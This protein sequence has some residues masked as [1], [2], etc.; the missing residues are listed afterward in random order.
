MDNS[1]WQRLIAKIGIAILIIALIDLVY[2]NW[3]ILQSQ[4]SKVK[5]QNL[6]ETRAVQQEIIEEMP[7]PSVI[8]SPKSESKTDT[9]SPETKT[10]ETKTI[11][12]RETQTIVQT[13][14]K[15]IFIPIGS[16]STK[17]NNYEDL[18][19]LEVTIDTNKYPNIESA[20]FEASIWVQDGNGKMF[21]QL[22][23]S[24][25][26]HPVWSSEISTS[27]SK[28]TLTSSPTIIL[29]KGSRTYRVQAKT[30]LTSYAAH[31]DNA[32]IKITLK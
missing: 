17:N 23:N 25:D 7:S 20:V 5:S 22:F 2:I 32:R 10:V 14:Q 1:L 30:N 12:E 21:A 28:A 13:A 27:S 3:W 31:V 4:S 18:A 19:G 6:E 8:P 11:V 15:E 9:K 16:G 26:K 24:T 29:E